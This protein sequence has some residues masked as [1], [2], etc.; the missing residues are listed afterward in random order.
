MTQKRKATVKGVE[1][2]PRIVKVTLEKTANLSRFGST[3]GSLGV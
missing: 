2:M 1:A 3:N